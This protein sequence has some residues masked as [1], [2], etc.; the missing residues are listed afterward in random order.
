VYKRQSLPNA[1][2]DTVIPKFRV[3]GDGTFWN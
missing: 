1:Y 2:T 3:F